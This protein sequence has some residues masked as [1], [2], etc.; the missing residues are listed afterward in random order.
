MSVEVAVVQILL[1]ASANN[2]TM[3]Q[4]EHD[5]QDVLRPETPD[6]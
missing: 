5:V 4:V 6:A 3:G 2:N 1:A